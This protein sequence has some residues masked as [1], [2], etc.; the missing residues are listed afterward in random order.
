MV[1]LCSTGLSSS[2]SWLGLLP[3]ATDQ[4][5]TAMTI[6]LKSVHGLLSEPRPGISVTSLVSYGNSQS[7]GQTRFEGW[8]S[9]RHLLL[10]DVWEPLYKGSGH[11][12]G[13][14]ALKSFLHSSYH[15]H[16]RI[17]VRT[18]VSWSQSETPSDISE[19]NCP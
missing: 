2:N 12:G 13:P 10:A 18:Q 6:P 1:H 8:R 11:R 15:T 9:V 16:Q 4:H 3:M 17:G 5:C 14:R 19:H 7:K